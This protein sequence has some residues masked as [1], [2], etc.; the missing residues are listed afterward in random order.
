[1][2]HPYWPLF[3]VEVHTPRVSLRYID[4]ELGVE[5]ATLAAG[6][7]HDP[8]F[9][10]FALAW[11]D[12]EPPQLQRNTLQYYWRTRAELEP[13]QWNLNFAVLADGTV[14]GSTG[15]SSRHFPTLRTF[16]TGSWLGKAFQGR[17][18][19][20]ELRAASL[21]LGFAGLGAEVAETTAYEDNAPSIGVTR[22]LGYSPNGSYRNKR[23]DDRAVVLRFAMTA[24]H[25]RSIRR[26]DIELTG[27]DE[28][29]AMLGLTC[30]GDDSG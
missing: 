22:S 28:V 6:G 29:L 3:D 17:G 14:I 1:M 16:E 13:E 10:P 12:V 20:K 9:M 30:D 18:F 8:S 2:V 23:R 4:D 26:D 24:E 21:H 19:G 27:V 15:L 7:V 5:L 11:T 25:W